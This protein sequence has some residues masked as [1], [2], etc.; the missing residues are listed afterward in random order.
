MLLREILAPRRH[1]TS[2]SSEENHD[3]PKSGALLST[4]VVAFAGVWLLAG[5]YFKLFKGSPSTLPPP[6][7]EF[8]EAIGLNLVLAYKLTIAIEF[9]VFILAVLRPRLA[10]PLLIGALLT[11]VT[12]LVPMLGEESCGCFGPDFPI[13]PKMML[14]YDSTILLG[15]LLTR[16]WS[17]LK[18][19]GAHLILVGLL[20]AGGVALP[21]IF[22]REL[23]APVDLTSEEQPAERPFVSLDIENWVGKEIWD[24]PLANVMDLSDPKAFPQGLWVFYRST[25]DHCAKHLIQLS[26]TEVGDR[27]ILLIR[28]KEPADNEGNRAVHVKPVGD[29]V[30]EIE[31]SDRVMYDMTT[32]A[33]LILDAGVILSADEGV[34]V[35]EH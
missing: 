33:D 13:A 4:L 11:F 15:I 19:G 5:G 26:N 17:R 29:Y 14:I 31:L 21:W 23:T 8:T 27:P 18:K 3:K 9:C 30:Q 10:W 1:E 22:S 2:M 24:T 28:L 6:V 7:R 25:C 16:P 35:D 32:P 20:L 34:E 12:I